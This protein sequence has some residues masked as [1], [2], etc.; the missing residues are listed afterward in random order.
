[1]AELMEEGAYGLLE[2]TKPTV[3]PIIW[4]TIATGKPASEHGIHGFVHGRRG[5]ELYSSRDRR[6]KALWNVLSDFGKRVAVV[7]WWNT[8]PAEAVAGV[9][10]AQTHR[11]EQLDRTDGQAILKGG[12]QVGLDKQV[13]P[14]ERA[15]DILA[16]A[17]QVA[18]GLD[19]ELSKA[20]AP[21]RHALPPFEDRLWQNTRWAFANDAAY[22]AI[23]RRLASEDFDLL[24]VYVGGAD[25]VGHRFWRY[26]EPALYRH[27]PAAE[28]LE[29]LGSVIRDY[30]RYLDRYL[31]VLIEAFP[32]RPTV[33]VIS[34]HGMRPVNRGARFRSDA[35]PRDISSAHHHTAPPGVFVAAGPSIRRLAVRPQP[36]A[37]N[38]DLPRIGSILDITP[39]VLALLGIPI[40]EDMPG[41]VLDQLLAMPVQVTTIATHDEP[42]WRRRAPGGR[43]PGDTDEAARLEQ[44]R[45]L[46]YIN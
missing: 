41:R 19:R 36:G 39:T 33:I 43:A 9:I 11:L 15:E 35:V 42:Q 22:L 14:P 8:Y 10:V 6:T 34:D 18:A 26:L 28:Q 17:G 13:H 12:L 30:Y 38:L 37:T 29:D 23:A 21:F 27:R 7:G 40:G 31:G 44:L 20:F 2:T 24:M 4:T 5:T 16:L 1:L 3:S 25:V 45:A 32:R 46:G